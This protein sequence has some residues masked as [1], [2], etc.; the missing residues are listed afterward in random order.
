MKRYYIIFL[1]AVTLFA[2][3]LAGCS[4]AFPFGIGAGYAPVDI[5]AVKEN[6]EGEVYFFNETIARFERFWVSNASGSSM[7]AVTDAHLLMLNPSEPPMFYVY[8][9]FFSLPSLNGWISNLNPTRSNALRGHEGAYDGR[10]FFVENGVP[11]YYLGGDIVSTNEPTPYS[12]EY[13][14]ATNAANWLPFRDVTV[15]T[16]HKNAVALVCAH[17]KSE[18]IIRLVDKNKQI[19]RSFV[20]NG[21]V[22]SIAS[23]GELLW[24]FYSEGATE[25]TDAH[26][27]YALD[28]DTGVITKRVLYPLKSIPASIAVTKTDFLALD[29]G[30]LTRYPL[31]T[32]TK[33]PVK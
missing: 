32:L 12:F 16:R 27:L 10:G 18:T 20:V 9:D 23:D 21:V 4:N 30:M 11:Y 13:Y 19:I 8:N 17:G 3:A 5:R 2:G 15:L 6:A 26:Y 33:E 28:T 7:L 24:F 22:M 14:F 1:F 25:K 31:R 29:R